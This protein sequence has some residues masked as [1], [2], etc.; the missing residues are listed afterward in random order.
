MISRL[1]ELDFLLFDVWDLRRIGPVLAQS[2]LIFVRRDSMLETA[3]ASII[4]AYGR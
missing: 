4:R 3:A 1:R 2:D